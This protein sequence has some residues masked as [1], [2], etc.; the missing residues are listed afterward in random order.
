MLPIL[1]LMDVV[2]LWA[3]RQSWDRPVVLTL[4]GGAVLG[5][6]IGAMTASFVQEDQV[7]LIVG[8]I[9]VLFVADRIRVRNQV[10]NPTSASWGK[11]SF[12]GSFA[13]FTSFVA[14]AGAPPFQIYMLPQKPDKTI[15]VGTAMV[16]FFLVNWIKLPFYAGLGLLAPTNLWTSLVLLPLAPIG[17]FLGIWLHR[18]IPEK[19]FFRLAY[20]FIFLLGLKLIWDGV[21]S[22][23]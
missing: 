23:F 18:I 2:G 13:G 20:G 10:T 14:H 1:M 17:I 8:L 12:W 15:Y 5:I 4:L 16:F 19:P 9:A 7:R 3:Y 22:L 11:G 21:S 6:V